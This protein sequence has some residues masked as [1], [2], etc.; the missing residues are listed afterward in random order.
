MFGMVSVKNAQFNPDGSLHIEVNVKVNS[1][2]W[3]VAHD[4]ERDS[5]GKVVAVSI[6]SIKPTGTVGLG[7]PSNGKDFELDLSE[8]FADEVAVKAT[9]G[10][11]KVSR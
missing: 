10:N 1:T 11:L 6:R 7:F 8:D 3:S 5:A 9:V 4:L 2:G